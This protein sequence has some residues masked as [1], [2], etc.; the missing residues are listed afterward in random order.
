MN[1]I[2]TLKDVEKR[3]RKEAA[4]MID[5]ADRADADRDNIQ[6]PA[7]SLRLYAEGLKEFAAELAAMPRLTEQEWEAAAFAGGTAAAESDSQI[8][9]CYERRKAELAPLVRNKKRGK[10]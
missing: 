5:S 8:Q 6:D 1:E 7:G 9:T 4:L 3:L 10:K 2:K